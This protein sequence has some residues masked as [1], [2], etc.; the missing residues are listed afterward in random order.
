MYCLNTEGGSELSLGMKDGQTDG[1]KPLSICAKLQTICLT[2]ANA[3]WDTNTPGQC[4]FLMY[5][6]ITKS[7]KYRSLW[8]TFSLRSNKGH[9]NSLIPNLEGT[10]QNYWIMKYMSKRYT[11]I[12][13]FKVGLY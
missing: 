11:F 5:K 10:R 6:K 8:P 7:M 13:W 3:Q 4:H 1:V 12:M 2:R 9:I